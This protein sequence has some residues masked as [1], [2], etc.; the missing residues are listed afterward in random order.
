MNFSPRQQY[1]LLRQAILAFGGEPVLRIANDLGVIE[2]TQDRIEAAS[3]AVVGDTAAVIAFAGQIEYRLERHI[4]VLVHEDLQLL[5][6]DLEVR[7]VEAWEDFR[8]N[9]V[10][11]EFRIYFLDYL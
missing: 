2:V 6:R 8:V 9:F 4:R 1:L 7:L 3:V 10:P 5:S 11:R